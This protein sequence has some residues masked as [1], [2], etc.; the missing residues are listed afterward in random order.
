M[1]KPKIITKDNK[2]VLRLQTEK[3][4]LLS[5]REVEALT[6][7]KV[8]GLFPV[9]IEKKGKRILFYYDVTGYITLESYLKSGLRKS[10]FAALLGEIFYTLQTLQEAF[11]SSTAMLLALSQVFISPGDKKVHFIF[12]PVQLYTANVPLRDFYLSV[13][14]S[15]VFSKDENLEYVDELAG[16]LNRGINLSL[17]DV[18]E[19]IRKIS[20]KSRNEETKIRCKKCNAVN[21]KASL[22]CITCGAVFNGSNSS[23][24]VSYDPLIT[25]DVEPVVQPVVQKQ[26]ATLP[27]AEPQHLHEEV[28]EVPEKAWII[29]KRTGQSF[30]IDKN[31][32]EIGKS[33]CDC[34]ITDNPVMSRAHAKI[35]RREGHFFAVDL[36]STNKTYINGRQIPANKEVELLPGCIIRFGNEEFE[37][38]A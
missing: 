9:K 11:F 20:V 35:L 19:Y 12:V 18:E 27:V 21:K 29:Q 24:G 10:T 5:A 2:T 22:F 34:N 13:A 38:R 32:Y 4:E 1:K 6:R 17:F 25:A 36:F 37:F 30:M 26:S 3:G 14:K 15:T 28:P 31:E 16:I 33:E 7:G 23:G 8:D